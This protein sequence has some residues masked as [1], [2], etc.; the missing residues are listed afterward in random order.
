[1]QKNVLPEAKDNVLL[2]S[3][4]KM[5]YDY[6]DI[7]TKSIQWTKQKINIYIYIYLHSL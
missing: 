7:S 6:I 4:M 2:S 3:I 1:M 5:N